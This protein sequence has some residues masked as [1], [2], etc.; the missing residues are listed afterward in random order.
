M[1]LKFR[2][3]LKFNNY[4]NPPTPFVKLIFADGIT[5]PTGII[6]AATSMFPFEVNK[7]P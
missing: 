7:D 5:N 1:G 4:H 6:V 3:P 2:K